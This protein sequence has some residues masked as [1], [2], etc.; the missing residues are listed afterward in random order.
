[1]GDRCSI[2]NLTSSFLT[3]VMNQARPSRAGCPGL[4]PHGFATYQRMETPQ[5]L[6]WTPFQ[7][8]TTWQKKNSVF[9]CPGGFSY[10]SVCA[11][12]LIPSRQADLEDSG[13]SP[14]IQKLKS[15]WEKEPLKMPHIAIMLNMKWD[16]WVRTGVWIAFIMQIVSL[17]F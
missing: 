9:W 2:S 15:K 7:Y 11:H 1:M 16:Q 3:H 13:I 6:C 8:K 4:C 10:V 5:L 17:L 12:C 14:S